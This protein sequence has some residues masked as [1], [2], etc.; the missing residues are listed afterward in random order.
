MLF[1]AYFPPRTACFELKSKVESLE[2]LFCNLFCVT[3]PSQKQVYGRIQYR[4]SKKTSGGNYLLPSRAI[5]KTEYLLPIEEPGN[6]IEVLF[7]PDTGKNFLYREFTFLYACLQTMSTEC[8]VNPGFKAFSL[9]TRRRGT[10]KIC[11]Y[12][13]KGLS[14]Y[15]FEKKE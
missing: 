10:K 4:S 12:Y 8:H 7:W 15:L 3:T 6:K 13:L 9:N 11:C 2:P 1:Q 14:N 5:E